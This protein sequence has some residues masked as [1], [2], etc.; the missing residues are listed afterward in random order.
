[1]H[2][3]E[4]VIVCSALLIQNPDSSNGK[5]RS[6]TKG[7]NTPMIWDIT[8]DSN[9]HFPFKFH[10][11]RGHYCYPTYVSY[12]GLIEDSFTNEE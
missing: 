10:N 1:M 11:T 2:G 7:I 3:T 5:R 12:S 8:F 6:K 9:G 4:V